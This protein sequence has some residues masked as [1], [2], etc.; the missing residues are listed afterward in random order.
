MRMGPFPWAPLSVIPA[1]SFGFFQKAHFM[2]AT[3]GMHHC[4]LRFQNNVHMAAHWTAVIQDRDTNVGKW[5]RCSVKFYSHKMVHGAK[6][7]FSW[8]NGLVEMLPL[9][10]SQWTFIYSQLWEILHEWNLFPFD[11]KAFPVCVFF[12]TMEFS[13]SPLI[14]KEYLSL[15]QS[16]PFAL[17]YINI[18][19]NKNKIQINSKSA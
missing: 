7:P 6:I 18:Y 1:L 9:G 13:C 10:D 8:S 11:L 4:V 3:P 17:G 15:E 16:L 14:L 5:L 19:Q 2:S 12:L